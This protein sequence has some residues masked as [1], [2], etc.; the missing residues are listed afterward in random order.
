MKDE[1]HIDLLEV[2]VKHN[3]VSQ[4]SLRNEKIRYEYKKMKENGMK[5]KDARSFLADKYFLSEKNIESVLY[6][7]KTG[8][9]ITD[10]NL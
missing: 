6:C 2:F 10:I 7:K 1:L 8:E 5:A 9:G 3:I 4:T